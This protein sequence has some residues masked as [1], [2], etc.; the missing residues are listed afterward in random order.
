MEKVKWFKSGKNYTLAP[1]QPDITEDLPN[2]LFIV[3]MCKEGLFLEHRPNGFEFPEKLYGMEDAFIERVVRTFEHTKDN[4]G[5]MLSGLRGTGKTVT[6]EMIAMKLGLPII[7]I[8]Q[9]MPGII[10]FID[11]FPHPATFLCDEFEKVFHSNGNENAVQ[12]GG[13]SERGGSKLLPLMDGVMNSKHRKV[14]I[15]TTNQL[16]VEPNLLQRPGRVRYLKE[17]SNLS[18]HSIEMIVDDLL[19]RKELRDV[20]IEF[21]AQ[22]QIITIDIVTTVIEE[23]NIHGGSPE[24]LDGLLNVKRIREK[25]DLSIVDQVTMEESKHRYG[26]HLDV[27]PT[28]DDALKSE[29]YVNGYSWGVIQSIKGQYITID[30]SKIL[31]DY[32]DSDAKPHDPSETWLV[33]VIK[34]SSYN[35]ESFGREFNPDKNLNQK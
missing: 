3:Q 14:F 31:Q 30:R 25:Y 29:F 34:R 10:D 17:F 21:I 12:I 32:E 6:A 4:L 13:S 16:T 33:R 26:L 11:A 20:T 19:V 18:R 7:L 5:V 2:G 22:L 8:T 27:D 35:H 24:A 15:L 1:V 23:M 9:D 28:S